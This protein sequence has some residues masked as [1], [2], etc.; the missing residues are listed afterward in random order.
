MGIENT[1]LVLLRTSELK[2][3]Y[4]QSPGEKMAEG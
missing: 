3:N 2:G 4:Y 1:F